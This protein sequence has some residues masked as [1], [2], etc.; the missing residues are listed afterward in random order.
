MATQPARSWSWFDA[1]IGLEH[2]DDLYE[3]LRDGVVVERQHRI[4]SP[5]TRHY[6]RGAITGAHDA[7]GFGAVRL[8]SLSTAGPAEPGDRFIVSV[9]RRTS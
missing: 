2:T 4:R 1:P 5:A 8:L 9:A 6:A 3:R 7:A